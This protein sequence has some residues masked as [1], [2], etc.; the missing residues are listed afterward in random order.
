M[1]CSLSITPV[2]TTQ[3]LPL[4]SSFHGPWGSAGG[5]LGLGLLLLLGR[6][7]LAGEEPSCASRPPGRPASWPP[8]TSRRRRPRR[9]PPRLAMP[10]IEP[11]TR[12]RAALLRRGPWRRAPGVEDPLALVV[13]GVHQDPAPAG[14][15]GQL[16][17][18]DQLGLVA[19]QAGARLGGDPVELDPVVGGLEGVGLLVLDHLARSRGPS[20]PPPR[21]GRGCPWG[22]AASGGW[23][24]PIGRGLELLGLDVDG[25]LDEGQ[26]GEDDEEGRRQARPRLSRRGG[27]PSVFSLSTDALAMVG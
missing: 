5:L 6:V 19:D 13:E 1:S 14:E 10:G 24:G 17:R 26:D 22:P 8:R 3:R 7:D 2:I 11:V 15:G 16:G 21:A 9:I 18:G 12:G 4:V 25:G 23:P 27:V 20:C